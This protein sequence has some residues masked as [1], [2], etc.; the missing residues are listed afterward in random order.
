MVE[1]RLASV[2]KIQR[3]AGAGGDATS[4]GGGGGEVWF[5]CWTIR[6]EPALFDAESEGL[7]VVERGGSYAQIVSVGN[8]FC[9]FRFGHG[10][11]GIFVDA[12]WGIYWVTS[13][14]GG[15]DAHH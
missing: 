13:V 7:C 3:V 6:S 4:G 5:F 12:G 11:G 9:G 15:L 1:G 8:Q 2:N 10:G 14:T